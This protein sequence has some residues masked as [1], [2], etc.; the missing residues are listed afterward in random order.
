MTILGLDCS[1]LIMKGLL[2]NF[3]VGRH[4]VQAAWL[5]QNGYEDSQMLDTHPPITRPGF[6]GGA[7]P[8]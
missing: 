2:G 1:K 4:I 7:C 5:R 6:A 3:L 8:S